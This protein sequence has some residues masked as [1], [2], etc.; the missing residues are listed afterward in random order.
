MWVNKNFYLQKFNVTKSQVYR[1]EV[2][3]QKLE[4]LKQGNQ[5]VKILKQGTDTETAFNP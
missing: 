4:K 3:H 1:S 5:K 2:G